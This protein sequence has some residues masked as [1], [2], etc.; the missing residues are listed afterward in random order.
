M[1]YFNFSRLTEIDFNEIVLSAGGKRFTTNLTISTNNCDY[2]LHNSLI[3]LKIIE[4]EPAEKETKQRKLAKLFRSDIK[5]VILNPV[6]LDYEGKNKYYNELSTPIKTALKKAS[7]QLKYSAESNEYKIAIILNNGLSMTSPDEFLDLAVKRAKNDTSNIDT[8]IVCGIYHYSDSF[9][10]KAISMFKDVLINSK[11]Q[12][13]NIIKK[14]QV[15]WN[16][17]V[18][19]YMKKQILDTDMER[20]KQ[21]VHDIYFEVDDIRYIKPPIQFGKESPFFGK[22]GRPRVD[23]TGMDSYPPVGIILPIFNIETY[24]YVKENIFEN[25]SYILKESLS[26]YLVWV[27]EEKKLSDD[28]FK[29]IIPIEVTVNELT[30]LGSAFSFL[31]ISN[32]AIPKFQREVVNIMDRKIEFTDNPISINYILLQVNEIGMDKANDIAFISHNK[33]NMVG[34]TQNILI[35]GERMKFDYAIMLASAYCLSLKADTV[36]YYINEDF[37]WK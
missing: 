21:P 35:K 12:P 19:E 24:N 11:E 5:T 13:T 10:T 3:E 7:K 17:K 8:L 2:I 22:V 26:K 1:E 29:P 30:T 20:S 14:L 16:E 15:A 28:I 34:E 23:T 4:E 32:L 31:D 33:T 37:K 6:D 9:E 27:D 18:N 25:D 36:Y